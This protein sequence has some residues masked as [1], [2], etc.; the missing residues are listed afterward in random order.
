MIGSNDIG[1]HDST[2][3]RFFPVFGIVIIS[4]SLVSFS[5][6]QALINV[7]SL[8]KA[9]LKSKCKKSGSAENRTR[10]L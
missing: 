5:R 10:Y 2:S 3:L 6:I 1:R 9:F 4:A 7:V 8:T